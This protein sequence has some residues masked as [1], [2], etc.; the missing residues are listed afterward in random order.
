MKTAEKEMI[1]HR[2]CFSGHRPQKLKQPIDDIKVDLENGIINA[3]CDGYCTFI[4][5]M[6][7]GTDI[8]AGNIVIRMKELYPDLKLIAAIPFPEFTARWDSVWSREYKRLLDKA[9]LIKTICP[10]YCETAYQKRNKWMVDHCSKL[11]AVYNGSAGGTR[12]TIQYARGNHLQ[13]H[14]IN[15]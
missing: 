8:W 6:S 7:C 15:G 5:G 12:S 9:D 10:Q 14:V 3:I 1:L 2:C 11:I 4:T 13:I